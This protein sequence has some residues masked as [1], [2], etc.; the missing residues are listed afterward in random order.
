MYIYKGLLPR[1]FALATLLTLSI[2]YSAYAGETIGA[3]GIITS[4]TTKQNVDSSDVLTKQALGLFGEGKLEQA[5]SLEEKAVKGEPDNWLVHSVLSYLYWQQG[6][7]P[8]S[9][10]EGQR[11]VKQAKDN[12]M[13]LINLGHIF[14]TLAS[15]VE[16]IPCYEAACKKD[17]DNWVP[18]IGLARCYI[19]S[20]RQSEALAVLEKMS[21]RNVANFDWNYRLGETYLKVDKPAKAITPLTQASSL[22]KSTEQKSLSQGLLLTALLR[23]NQNYQAEAIKDQCFKDAMPKTY[24]PYI[25]AASALLP[26]ADP[27]KGNALFQ[28]A[29]ENLQASSDSEGFFRLGRVFEEKANSIKDDTAKRN[30]WLDIA[31]TALNQSIELTPGIAKNYLALAAVSEQQ[32]KHKE[33]LEEISQAK[34]YDGFDMVPPFLLASAK[35][36]G[37]LHL[38]AVRFKINGLTCGCQASRI[39]QVLRSVNKTALVR[40]SHLKPYEGVVLVD[41]E[42]TSIEKALSEPIA[43]A[44]AKMPDIPAHPAFE[45][46]SQEPVESVWQSM[47]ITDKARFGD[48]LEF[49]K[50]FDPMHPVMPSILLTEHSEQTNSAKA[51]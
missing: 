41:P 33:M 44:F 32:G 14:Q 26:A 46:V 8:D 38:A 39:E 24:E 50:Q 17:P 47:L 49:P 23:N 1:A 15:Y 28:I 43:N 9:I 30:A 21:E 42:K 4:D 18:W 3:Q 37:T 40:F 2:P 7:V 31:A 27:E 6:N 34:S 12:A 48:V 5:V 20:E 19:G 16:A 35:E 25:R 51:F 45:V 10:V 29:K 22:A 36:T 11:A 13:P